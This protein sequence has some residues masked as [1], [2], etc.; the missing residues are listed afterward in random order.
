MVIHIELDHMP[1]F[2]IFVSV[3]YCGPSEQMLCS[4]LGIVCDT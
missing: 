1:G 4:P 3:V 2:L